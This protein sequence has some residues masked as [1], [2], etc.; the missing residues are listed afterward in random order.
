MRNNRSFCDNY[1][2]NDADV[3]VH[4]D[5]VG[6]VVHVTSDSRYKAPIDY[7]VRMDEAELRLME[8][9]E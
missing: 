2:K 6:D 5:I 3:V 4:L 8:E 1:L 9:M 7:S